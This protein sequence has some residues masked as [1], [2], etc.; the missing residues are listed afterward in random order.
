VADCTFID[1]TCHAK[2]LVSDGMSA[3]ARDT[4]ERMCH[5]FADA[6]GAV[7]NAVAGNFLAGS[8]ID[9]GHSASIACSPS[10]RRSAVF[11]HW[12]YWWAR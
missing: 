7:L 4:F 1:G 10:V 3:V 9:L 6:G 2:N 11:W 12:S 5:A 8:S